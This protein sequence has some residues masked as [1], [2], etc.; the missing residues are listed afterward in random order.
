MTLFNWAGSADSLVSTLAALVAVLL[1]T[2]ILLFIVGYFCGQFRSSKKQ[3]P[4]ANETSEEVGHSQIFISLNILY[5][6]M[7]RDQEQEVELKQ[8]EAYDPLR[9]Q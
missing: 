1:F 5:E 7:A 3:K 6:V 2:S 4:A 8:N 9:P